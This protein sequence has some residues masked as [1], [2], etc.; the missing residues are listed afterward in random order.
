MAQCTREFSDISPLRGGN[1]VFDTLEG[2]PSA[3]N[4]EESEVFGVKSWS[5]VSGYCSVFGLANFV[6]RRTNRAYRMPYTMFVSAF[7]HGIHPGYFLS[8]L[9]IPLCTSAEDR[10]FK[11]FPERPTWLRHL[12]SF[13]RMRG[14]EMMA[15]GFL[16]L[17]GWDT[18]RLWSKM[19]FW[20]HLVMLCTILALKANKMLR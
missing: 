10:L 13:V 19:Y 9:T 5:R 11:A 14:F 2:R 8:F 16:L 6:Y 1:V 4:F 20:L 17:D 18:I 12:W 15:C 3:N 7:W